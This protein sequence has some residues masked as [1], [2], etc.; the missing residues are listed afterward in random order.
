[1]SPLSQRST[2]RS[3]TR[4][5]RLQQ[6]TAQCAASIWVTA[7]VG[8]LVGIAFSLPMVVPSS[9][10]NSA[11]RSTVPTG[12]PAIR[13]REQPA[14]AWGPAP[15]GSADARRSSRRADLKLRR[16][17]EQS[18]G[19]PVAYGRR[20]HRSVAHAP[21]RP[22]VKRSSHHLPTTDFW[23]ECPALALAK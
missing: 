10:C 23:E 15:L 12:S 13:V 19:S 5:S 18:S 1:M 16:C 3:E 2:R 17:T 9:R 21:G 14:A 8:F 20:S 7:A 4:M 11:M 22:N 6:A